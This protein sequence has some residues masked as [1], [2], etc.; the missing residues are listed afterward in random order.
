MLKSALKLLEFFCTLKT[1]GSNY[2]YSEC[3]DF[4][5]HSRCI[6][7]KMISKYHLVF[8]TSFSINFQDHL[9]LFN[10]KLYNFVYLSEI[11]IQE[12]KIGLEN[13]YKKKIQKNLKFI[14]SKLHRPCQQKFWIQFKLLKKVSRV[15]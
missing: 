12:I 15:K 5:V 2:F 14:A 13:L 9:Q 1:S 3:Y 8:C 4:E 11:K 10:A 6:G 7:I